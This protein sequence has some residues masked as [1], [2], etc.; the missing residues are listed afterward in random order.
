MSELIYRHFDDHGTVVVGFECEHCNKDN[1][2]TGEDADYL[3]ATGG[4]SIKTADCLFCK[5]VNKL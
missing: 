1:M 5:K 2:F 3:D 4:D